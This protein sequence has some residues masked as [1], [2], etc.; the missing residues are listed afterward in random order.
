M[1]DT[2]LRILLLSSTMVFGSLIAMRY[3]EAK[4]I[5]AAP[6][7]EPPK[8]FAQEIKVG[9]ELGAIGEGSSGIGFGGFLFK[10]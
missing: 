8:V 3:T 1:R 2:V 4:T 9:A 6:V 7:F 5:G 10:E